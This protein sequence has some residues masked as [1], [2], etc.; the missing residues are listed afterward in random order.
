MP[1]LDFD[2]QLDTALDIV[3]NL[4]DDGFTS[5]EIITTLTRGLGIALMG[6]EEGRV[7]EV[8]VFLEGVGEV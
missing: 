3:Q 7:D 5:D 1:R 8:F 4:R 2:D 6:D